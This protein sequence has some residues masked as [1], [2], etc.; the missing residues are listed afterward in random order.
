MNYSIE[1]MVEEHANIVRMLRVVQKICCNILEGAEPNVD[2]FFE[3]IDFIR[4]YA[5]FHHHG[6]EEKF[7]FPEMIERLGAVGE[8][9]VKHGMLVEHDLGRNFVKNLETSLIAWREE[10]KTEHKLNILTNAMGYANLLHVHVEKENNVVYTFAERMLPQDLFEEINEKSRE[11]EQN[12]A[13]EG[14]QKKYLD[15]LEKLERKYEV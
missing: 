13:K 1:V 9:L 12:E 3:I 8:N 14:I 7:L 6:K 15:L 2:E 11:F 4:N 10:P 5:D